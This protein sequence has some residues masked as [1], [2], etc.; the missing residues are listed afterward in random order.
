MVFWFDLVQDY[1][2][3]CLGSISIQDESPQG[4]GG[5]MSWLDFS[6]RRSRNETH[7]GAPA[8]SQPSQVLKLWQG[9]RVLTIPG[10]LGPA[11]V[12]GPP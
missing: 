10:V 7:S 1:S 4:A 5:R 3:R 12:G 9:H 2:L 6:L 8:R 11:S